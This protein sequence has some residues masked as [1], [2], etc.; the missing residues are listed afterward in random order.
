MTSLR[1]LPR[2]ALR[3]EVG[4]WHSLYRWLFRRPTTREASAVPF[5]YSSLLTPILIAFIA[6]SA[7][8]IPVIH[9]F[10]PWETIGRIFLGLG[11]WGLVWM[12]GLLAAIRI[13][14]HL[15][16]ESGLRIR[17]GFD[18][19]VVLPWDAVEAVRT[20][21]RSYASG[22]KV[23][24]E[25]PEAPTTLNAPISSTTNVE[26]VLRGPTTVRLPNGSQAT[27]TNVNV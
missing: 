21:R 17:Y 26:V 4:I 18:L 23:Q 12:V 10:V 6:V 13:H 14:P 24:L 16:G 2:R 9:F 22:R 5:G 7:L 25:P 1:A 27:V 11:V 3:Y 20:N 8:E 19:D 15:V